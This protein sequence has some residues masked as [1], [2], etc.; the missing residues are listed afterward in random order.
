VLWCSIFL[1]AWPHT[2]SLA[3]MSECFQISSQRKL[4]VSL[5]LLHLQHYRTIRKS[6]EK[7][8]NYMTTRKFNCRHI[9]VWIQTYDVTATSTISGCWTKTA[10]RSAGAIWYSEW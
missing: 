9:N 6:K 10:S 7:R 2:P 3:H 1:P 5:Q 4:L 8:F